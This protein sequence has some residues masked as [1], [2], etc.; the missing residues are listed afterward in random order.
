M[1]GESEIEPRCPNCGQTHKA[2]SACALGVFLGVIEDRGELDLETIT[3]QILGGIDADQFWGSFGGP[4][5]EWLEDELLEL[6]AE[7]VGGK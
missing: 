7:G 5:V 6:G 4:A 1:N 2:I 3:P